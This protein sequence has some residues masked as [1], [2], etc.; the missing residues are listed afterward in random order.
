MEYGTAMSSD[1]NAIFFTFEITGHD[2]QVL[3]G[4][5]TASDGSFAGYSPFYADPNG[6]NLLEFAR[7]LQG[8]PRHVE[9]VEEFSFGILDS[10]PVPLKESG[11]DPKRLEAFVGLKFFCT[12]GF[13]HPAVRIVFRLAPRS[14]DL[15]LFYPTEASFVMAFYPAQ[16]DRFVEELLILAQDKYGIATLIGD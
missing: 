8:F 1:L 10:Y 13:G 6:E 2:G 11:L 9:Q 15:Q 7:I 12:D 14:W 5:V 16:L 3:V 4:K